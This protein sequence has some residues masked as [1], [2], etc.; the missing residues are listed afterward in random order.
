[1][2]IMKVNYDWCA[3]CKNKY[4]SIPCIDCYD[5]KTYYDHLI[6]YYSP[7]NYQGE[8]KDKKFIEIRGN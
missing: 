1:M 2:I 3:T 8:D 6:L 5:R 7:S 4:G